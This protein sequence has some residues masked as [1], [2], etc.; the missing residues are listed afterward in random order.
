MLN[1]IPVIAIIIIVFVFISSPWVLNKIKNKQGLHKSNTVTDAD[2]KIIDQPVSFGYKCMWF[3]VKSDHNEGLIKS[4][5][6]SDVRPC[7]WNIGIEKAYED[8]VF[9]TPPINGWILACGRRLP[10]GDSKEGIELV[11]DILR[12]LSK[13]YGEAQFFCTHRVTEYHCWIKAVE[14]NIQRVYSY[15]GESGENIMIE[16]EATDFEKTLHL[17]NTFSDDAKEK[18]Y[19]E[20]EDVSLPDEEIVMKVAENWSIDPTTIES[21]NDITPALG[22]LGEI[23]QRVH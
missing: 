2:M 4:L 14:G 18:N 16:G 11:K 1:N 17:V 8:A 15:L 5:N 13:E 20:R 7:N 23:S 9:I 12:K 6:L 22:L 10:H 19:F 3:A 21:R